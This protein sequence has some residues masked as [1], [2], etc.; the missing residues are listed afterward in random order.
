MRVSWLLPVALFSLLAVGLSPGQAWAQRRGPARPPA[1]SPFLS[2]G[3]GVGQNQGLNYFNIVR[4]TLEN[5]AL[6]ARQE[7]EIGKIERELKSGRAAPGLSV[8][9]EFEATLPKTGHRVY[10]SNLSH[11]YP[12][13]KLNQ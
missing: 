8:A 2:L 7:A 11:Y 4:P 12:Q 5:R 6:Q 9:G 1:V 3:A 10:Y 13:A